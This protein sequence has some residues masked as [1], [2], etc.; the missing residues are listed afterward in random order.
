M[1]QRRRIGLFLAGLIIGCILVYFMLF[2]GQD[3]TYWL[4][5]NR[6]KEQVSKSRVVFSEYAKCMMACRGISEEEVN[7]ILKEGDVN[8]GDSDIHNT[9]CP[10][11]A[12]DGL[13]TTGKN[14]R[15]VCTACDSVAEVTTA[16]RLDEVKDACK[17]R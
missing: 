8:F 4:P 9:P 12:F 10:S 6:L 13:T 3:R 2:R 7:H 16:I 17:C 5:E 1:T 14:V 15:I 11:Y